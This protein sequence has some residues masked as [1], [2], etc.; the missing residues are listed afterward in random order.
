MD[1]FYKPIPE[2]PE[3]TDGIPA[4]D[5]PAAFDTELLLNCLGDLRQ[6]IEVAIPVYEYSHT[7]VG[8]HPARQQF[9]APKG[10]VFLDGI[11]SYMPILAN[12]VD[13][14]VYVERPAALRRKARIQ[15]DSDFRG[16]TPYRAAEIYDKASRPLEKVYV[17]EQKCRCH[18][19]V[20]NG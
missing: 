17:Y 7:C 20:Q 19:V 1:S 18:L 15:R 5:S 8:R 12:M 3:F 14:A 9:I 11:L 4:F 10:I 6:G 2:I 16:V 13:F